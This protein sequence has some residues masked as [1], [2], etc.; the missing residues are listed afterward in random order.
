MVRLTSLPPPVYEPASEVVDDVKV[1][2]KA[3]VHLQ[4][5]IYVGVDIAGRIRNYMQNPGSTFKEI[6]GPIACKERRTEIHMFFKRQLFEIF[7][8]ETTFGCIKIIKYTKA[9]VRS[10]GLFTPLKLIS[11]SRKRLDDVE[12]HGKTHCHF[13]LYKKNL[14]TKNAINRLS[15]AMEYFVSLYYLLKNTTASIWCCRLKG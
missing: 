11:V 2:S 6:T 15:A 12:W 5:M 9:L 4:L 13:T 14:T 10:K 7:R 8:T 3:E 1:M